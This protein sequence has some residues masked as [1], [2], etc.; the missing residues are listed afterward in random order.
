MCSE[1]ERPIAE[2]QI[3]TP[4][5]FDTVNTPILYGRD[6]D[7]RDQRGGP[8]IAIVNERLTRE[9]FGTDSPLGRIIGT[10]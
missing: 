2:L 8:Q 10:G 9:A 5:Y 6:F 7:D 3:V 4:G 1:G